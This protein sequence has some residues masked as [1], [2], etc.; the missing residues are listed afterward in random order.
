MRRHGTL[1][2]VGLAAVLCIAD[3]CSAGGEVLLSGGIDRFAFAGR[4]TA[5]QTDNT[6]PGTSSVRRHFGGRPDMVAQRNGWNERVSIEA[7]RTA[8]D[9]LASGNEQGQGMMRSATAD[10]EIEVSPNSTRASRRLTDVAEVDRDDATE[11]TSA[12][13]PTLEGRQVSAPIAQPERTEVR[14]LAASSNT[15]G[16]DAK[17]TAEIDIQSAAMRQRVEPSVSQLDKEKLRNNSRSATTGL[18]YKL[19]RKTEPA[20]TGATGYPAWAEFALGK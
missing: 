19:R 12:Y 4:F 20:K 1:L 14:P 11:K 13:Y 6:L 16:S 15:D 17:G 18:R 7:Q 2:G 3:D 5:S 10:A 8:P 9:S